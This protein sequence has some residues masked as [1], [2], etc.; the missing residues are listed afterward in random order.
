MYSPFILENVVRTIPGVRFGTVMKRDGRVCAYLE[1]HDQFDV[2]RF[3][4]VM[5]DLG[6]MEVEV[7][8]MAAIPRDKRHFS[9][10]DY[11]RL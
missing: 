1:V 2:Q 10:I 11:D 3:R 6:L 9:K 8:E 7:V 4:K 5:A